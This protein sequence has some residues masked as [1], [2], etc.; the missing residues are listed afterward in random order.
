LVVQLDTLGQLDTPREEQL[1][2][3]KRGLLD[4]PT[5]RQI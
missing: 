4:T 3:L 2:T 5:A 1:D